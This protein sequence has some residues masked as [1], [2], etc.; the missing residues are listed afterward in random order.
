MPVI[1]PKGWN[2]YVEFERIYGAVA[3][4]VVKCYV[5]NETKTY[6]DD[7]TSEMNYDIVFLYDRPSINDFRDKF[8]PMI[9]KYDFY[10]HCYNSH[11]VKQLFDNFEEAKEVAEKENEKILE[12]TLDSV[13]YEEFVTHYD[14][15]CEEHQKTLDRYQK[16][17]DQIEQET[18]NIKITKCET[19]QTLDTKQK[20]LKKTR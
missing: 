3:N 15:I 16:I 20:Q 17:E 11:K 18:N 4:I 7:G 13:S 8:E 5:I 9:P 14:D 2:P 6:F 1:V 19:N 12:E 10:Y